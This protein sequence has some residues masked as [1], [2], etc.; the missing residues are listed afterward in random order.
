MSDILKYEPVSIPNGLVIDFGLPTSAG[1]MLLTEIVTGSVGALEA[2]DKANKL[3]ASSVTYQLAN[4][5][6]NLGII[7]LFF[8]GEGAASGVTVSEFE[9]YFTG[10]IYSV[11]TN[12][13]VL[14]SFTEKYYEISTF[15]KQ[16]LLGKDFLTY[17]HKTVR[18]PLNF[19]ESH[20]TVSDP[21][22][23]LDGVPYIDLSWHPIY[24]GHCTD[25]AYTNQTDCENSTMWGYCREL[26]T[27]PAH[28]SDP[29][30]LTQATCIWTGCSDPQFTN[31]TDCQASGCSDGITANP[32]ACA[33]AGSCDIDP[34]TNTT[35]TLCLA[36]TGVWT[37]ETWTY[38]SVWTYPSTW[39]P[40]ATE[41][42]GPPLCVRKNDE[43]LGLMEVQFNPSN[44]ATQC[45]GSGGN[46]GGKCRY[47]VYNDD[48]NANWVW[49]NSSAT[50]EWCMETTQT[51]GGWNHLFWAWFEDDNVFNSVDNNWLPST[52]TLSMWQHYNLMTS[53]APHIVPGK[54]LEHTT[55]SIRIL[56]TDNHNGYGDFADVGQSVHPWWITNT[57]DFEN[58]VPEYVPTSVTTYECSGT[59]DSCSDGIMITQAAC[60]AVPA[61]WT[62]ITHT[63]ETDCVNAGFTWDGTTVTTWNTV[64][65]TYEHEVKIDPDY[66]VQTGFS[67]HAF[68]VNATYS[69]P[70]LPYGYTDSVNT[71]TGPLIRWLAPQ[72]NYITTYRQFS[73]PDRYKIYRSPAWKND[74]W[75]TGSDYALGIWT[76]CG[77]EP[78]TDDDNY[79][80]FQDDKQEL[81]RGGTRKQ[82]HVYYKVTAEW[83]KWEW[84]QGI[85][86]TRWRISP[87]NWDPAYNSNN[88]FSTL[89]NAGYGYCSDGSSMGYSSCINY[90]WCNGGGSNGQGNSGYDNNPSGCTSTGGGS[91]NNGQCF[92]GGTQNGQWH[93]DGS[94]DDGYTGNDQ[95]E[96]DDDDGNWVQCQSSSWGNY[97]YQY[98]G[99]TWETNAIDYSFDA[100]A[101]IID[102][103]TNRRSHR[104]KGYFKAPSTETYTFRVVGDDSIYLWIGT[105]SQTPTQV[106]Q[107]VTTS[108]WI[109]AA[110]GSHGDVSNSGT[111]SMIEGE[112]YPLVLY[113]GNHY[114]PGTCHMYWSTPTIAEMSNGTDKFHKELSFHTNDGQDNVEGHPSSEIW[115]WFDT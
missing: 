84:K 8:S 41:Q 66:Y 22:K 70:Q 13:S 26:L 36:A 101:V 60:E 2:T 86:Y 58:P 97:T 83:D 68:T 17:T 46:N 108:N 88:L 27:T 40:L 98:A 30:L 103:N 35:Q 31:P 111:I 85:D 55:N 92:G 76:L 65:Y 44:V 18:N 63:N 5:P 114:G 112:I 24:T 25:P 56:A 105:T 87:A 42:Q 43:E 12:V 52:S 109:A 19:A 80:Y 62:S 110:P 72:Q 57:F 20:G 75:Y 11:L 96:C 94:G 16:S 48:V 100:Q 32:T 64:W 6:E 113:N 102:D 93:C 91:W 7:R 29:L 3:A 78:H 33:A 69:Q 38:P 82:Q 9:E 21:S 67:P 74:V 53:Y 59:T 28:C 49:Y 23:D 115:S 51:V 79:M 104:I 61:T 14:S 95:G 45:L 10:E 99:Y 106:E 37:F 34:T 47:S 73:S 71:A 81:L 1:N 89:Y 107:S 4:S 77:V 39:Y 15:D 90:G 54:H 50:K